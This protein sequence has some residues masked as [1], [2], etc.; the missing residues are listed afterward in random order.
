MMMLSIIALVSNGY[1]YLSSRQKQ[2]ETSSS[3]LIVIETMEASR[4]EVSK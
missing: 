2:M 4:R 1:L 3:S